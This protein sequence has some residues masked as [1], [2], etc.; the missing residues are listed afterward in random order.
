MSINTEKRYTLPPLND[1]LLDSIIFAMENK[2][3]ESYLDVEKGVV[4]LASMEDNFD[5]NSPKYIDLPEWA[6]SDGFHLMEVFASSLKNKVYADKLD[7]ALHR[8]RG[9]FRKFKDVLRNQPLLEKQ[10]FA[11]KDT[12]MKEA[13]I[14]WYKEREGV[15]SLSQESLSEEELPNELL[16]GDFSVEES[17]PSSLLLQ[18]QQLL[19]STLAH[20]DEIDR[21]LIETSEKG[22]DKKGYLY[23]LSPVNEVVAFLEYGFLTNN[24]WEIICYGVAPEY[25]DL[26]IFHLMFDRLSRS[27]A[28]KKINTV[29]VNFGSQCERLSGILQHIEVTSHFN[30][31]A[32]SPA[33]WNENSVSSELLEV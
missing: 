19:D 25:V 24:I 12:K 6:P 20:L 8:G 9:V 14:H 11:F 28:R 17:L 16:I 30:Q 1:F 5:E 31:M 15:I 27:A 4:V 13:V 21:L 29:V 18:A 3:E 2:T 10:W 33:Q 22:I 23:I 7:K 32:F 26:G